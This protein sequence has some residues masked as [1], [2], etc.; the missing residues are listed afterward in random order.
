M[1]IDA[2]VF[3]LDGTLLTEQKA[4]SSVTREK[5]R[6]LQQKGVKIVF[7]TGRNDIYTKGVAAQIGGVEAV[8]GSNGASI[9]RLEDEKILYQRFIAPVA[10]Q[11]LLDYALKHDFDIMVSVFGIMYCTANSKRVE[12]YHSYNTKAA[13]EYQVPLKVI[14]EASEVSNQRVM[15]LFIWKMPEEYK[16]EFLALCSKF[17][18]E[19]VFSEADG[20][21]ISPA[22]VSKGEAVKNFAR[23]YDLSL[24][25]MAAFG[26]HDNDVSM[27]SIVGYPVAMGNAV[28]ALKAAAGY[29]TKSNN[30]DGIAWAIDNYINL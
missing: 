14:S 25:K 3:D 8:I 10:V 26:D 20:L 9:R 4:I 15:K 11:E 23:L 30:E 19:L 18:I 7:A 24:T 22:G 29:V 16:A 5:I 21:D 28:P 13:P 17:D 27:L 2:V 1:K 6:E 12:Y